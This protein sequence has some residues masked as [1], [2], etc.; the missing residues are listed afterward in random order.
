M[1]F[2]AKFNVRARREFIQEKHQF[3][4]QFPLPHIWELRIG[5]CKKVFD[6]FLVQLAKTT[7]LNLIEEK[8]HHSKG[9]I[10]KYPISTPEPMKMKPMLL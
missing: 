2:I 7:S 3:E 9:W 6:K 10:K 1:D 5:V 8:A 4:A